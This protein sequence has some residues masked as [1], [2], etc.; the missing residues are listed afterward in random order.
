MPVVWPRQGEVPDRPRGRACRFLEYTD[1]DRA[2]SWVKAQREATADS[3]G[4]ADT[5]VSRQLWYLGRIVLPNGGSAK[6][7]LDKSS[8]LRT[9]DKMRNRQCSCLMRFSSVRT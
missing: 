9:C 2:K 3:P 6:T 7:R 8:G 5:A 1:G 4:E